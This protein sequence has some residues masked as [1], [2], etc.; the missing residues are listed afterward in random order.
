MREAIAK[1]KTRSNGVVVLDLEMNG[2]Y[3]GDY[4]ISQ[5]HDAVG[6]IN[7]M[8]QDAKDYGFSEIKLVC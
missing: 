6:Q 4:P 8:I 1:I 2:S 5:N 7:M 3:Y